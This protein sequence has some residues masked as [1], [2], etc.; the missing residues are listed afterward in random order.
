MAKEYLGDGAYVD[1]DGYSLIL[2]AENGIR[3]TDTVVLEPN[4]WL[5]LVA[6]VER[7][8]EVHTSGANEDV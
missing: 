1:Y 3:A 2:T 7:L 4:V 8:K 5:A 6:Y